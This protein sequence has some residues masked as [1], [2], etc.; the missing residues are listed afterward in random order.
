MDSQRRPNAADPQ[1]ERIVVCADRS[2]TWQDLRVGAEPLLS[3]RGNRLQIQRS[4]LQKAEDSSR[5]GRQCA[6]RRP[7]R[8]ES[9]VGQIATRSHGARN[10][11]RKSDSAIGSTAAS[12]TSP[13]RINVPHRS[14]LHSS[15]CI[16]QSRLM[17]FRTQRPTLSLRAKCP[18]AKSAYPNASEQSA[19]AVT[20]KRS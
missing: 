5:T 20:T 17:I 18:S 2:Q 16:V 12:L 13:V 15:R 10:A 1:A 9:K 6:S 4:P 14:W 19:D 8:R 3:D 11:A 7:R